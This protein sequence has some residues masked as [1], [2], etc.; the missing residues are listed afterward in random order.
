MRQRRP[1]R[2]WCIVVGMCPLAVLLATRGGVWARTFCAAAGYTL[3]ILASSVADSVELVLGSGATE[4]VPLAPTVIIKALSVALT[5]RVGWHQIRRIGERADVGRVSREDRSIS[6]ATR[7]EGR[8][9]RRL[10]RGGRDG[11]DCGVW[12]RGNS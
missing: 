2:L 8:L 10:R 9:G 3:R 12:M 11:S 6:L 7:A 1:A 5:H 4:A